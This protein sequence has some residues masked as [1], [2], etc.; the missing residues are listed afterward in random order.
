MPRCAMLRLLI[1]ALVGALLVTPHAYAGGGLSPALQKA[2]AHSTYVYIASTRK[3]GKLG[4]PAEIW[5][6]YHDGAVYVA[7]PPTTWRVRRIKA[8]RTTAKIA[9][10]KPEGPSFMATGAIVDKPDLY[11]V[12]FATYAKKYGEA[13]TRFEPRFRSGLKDGSRLLIKYTPKG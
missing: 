10:G 13:W 3:S 4:K 2:L 1:A 12:L 8:G 11:P 7:S 9:V 5:F 6:M